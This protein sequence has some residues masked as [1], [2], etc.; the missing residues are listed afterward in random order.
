M[1]EPVRLAQVL[2]ALSLATDLSAGQSPES[3]LSATV[4]AVRM[5]R[6]MGVDDKQ[7]TDTYYACIT[8]F[9]GCTSTAESVAP[10]TLGDELSANL[11]FSLADPAD[12]RSVRSQMLT[13]F[14]V[15]EPLEQRERVIEMLLSVLDEV[16]N[17]AV[18]HCEQAIALSTRLPVPQAVPALLANLESRWDGRNPTRKGGDDVPLV[19]RIVEFCVVAE[20]HRRAGGLLSMLEIARNRAGGQFDPAVCTLFVKRATDLLDGF[21]QHSNWVL[22]LDAEPGE[23][24]LVPATELQ[25]VAEAFADFT[26]CRALS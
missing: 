15:E 6:A 11:A 24:R 3:A 22:Y 13:H 5:A 17:Y 21:S 16:P 12:P 18:P 2:G 25:S 9:I 14:A 8:R 20:L 23:P 7:L 19:S 26:E 1:D 4:L 10:I